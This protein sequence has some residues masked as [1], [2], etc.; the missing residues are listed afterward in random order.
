[1]I[2]LFCRYF[3]PPSDGGGNVF[4]KNLILKF[5]ESINL[6]T[7]HKAINLYKKYINIFRLPFVPQQRNPSSG[8]RLYWSTL[9]LFFYFLKRKAQIKKYGIHFGTLWP[10][11]MVGL[12]LAKLFGV[13]YTIFILGE[14][15]SAIVY[16]KGMKIKLIGFIYRMIILDATHVFAYSSFV[17]DNVRKLI[18]GKLPD[19]INVFPT[20]INQD[21]FCNHK[22]VYHKNFNPKENEKILFTVCRHI[23]RK[24]V[25]ILIDSVNLLNSEMKNWHLYIG[26]QGDYTSVLKEMV[27][28]NNLTN[29]VTFLGLLKDSELHGCYRRADIFILPNRIL[30]NGDADGCPIVFIEASSYGVPC[31]GGNVPGTYD[32]IVDGE[33][34][35]VVDPLDTKLI[36]DRIALLM[37]NENIR[38]KMGAK[39]SKFIETNYKWRD[40][41]D[42]FMEINEKI[43]N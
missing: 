4:F 2:N 13:K 20:G 3:P 34:G 39:A 35:F 25:D 18:N 30:D 8:I 6:Y 11:G 41:I 43:S 38:K 22:W 15:L 31:I 5:E 26:G 40:R 16:G 17:L 27:T 12:I 42:K 10:Y 24:G 21:V 9:L 32:A 23:Q 28:Q 36:S 14:E 29:K 1:M 37:Q 19:S 33:T 7:H